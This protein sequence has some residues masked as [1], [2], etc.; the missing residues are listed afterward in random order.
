MRI[1]SKLISVFF[2]SLFA[3]NSLH[4]SECSDLVTSTEIS[5]CLS[6]ELRD[7]DNQVNQAYEMLIH[8]LNGRE[9]LQVRAQQREWI[10]KRDSICNLDSNE[11]NREKWFQDISKDYGNTLC[12]IRQ[13]RKR[14]LELEAMLNQ[15]KFV[16]HGGVCSKETGSESTITPHANGK[17]YFEIEINSRE[18]DKLKPLALSIGVRGNGNQY[19][20]VETLATQG[21]SNPITSIEIAVDLNKG[22]LYYA[23][24]GAWING[25]PDGNEGIQI[26]LG[27][28][29]FGT[30]TISEK[31]LVPYL[32]KKGIVPNFGIRP[33][34]Y[35]PAGYLPWLANPIAAAPAVNPGFLQRY[36]KDR[37]SAD[38]SSMGS[39]VTKIAHSDT[40]KFLLLGHESGDIDIWDMKQVFHKRTIKAHGH[41][42]NLLAFSM[43][44][45]IFF[46]DSYFERET[47]VWNA[48]TGELLYT[49]PDTSGP[50]SGTADPNLVILASDSQLRILDMAAKSL[51]PEKYNF[52]SGV[53]TSIAYHRLSNLAAIGTASGTIY[54]V[55]LVRVCDEIKLKLLGKPTEASASWVI[56]LG[57]SS[58]GSKLYSV[59][60]FGAVSEW[61]VQGLKHI[62]RF[63]SEIKNGGEAVFSPENNLILFAGA[64]NE[65]SFVEIISTAS[66]KIETQ[67]ISGMD[68]LGYIPSLSL[69]ITPGTLFRVSK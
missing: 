56:G 8:A 63:P 68:Q 9:K 54:M 16:E 64:G 47:K 35:L 60:R 42:A 69:A 19:G 67:K 40:G 55:K 25:R 4:A 65:D 45:S 50:V 43:D 46:S 29:Y 10:G 57:F 36:I 48:Q 61:A 23:K 41:R 26:P 33:L 49:I 62:R 12:V 58:D 14:A 21:D 18:L 24:N 37:A 15:Y 52:S 17:W 53:I 3:S 1:T 22:K 2:V 27:I 44:G 20:L 7:T 13:T 32:E 34:K 6:K 30:V 28:N 59:G 5:Q 66:G 11:S 39:V 51:L 31:S 38:N